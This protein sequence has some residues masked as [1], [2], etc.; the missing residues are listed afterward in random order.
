MI[1]RFVLQIIL[2]LIYISLA[3]H[4]PNPRAYSSTPRH[5]WPDLV[6]TH[7]NTNMLDNKAVP[8]GYGHTIWFE[9][10]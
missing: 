2:L 9:P 1:N 4:P 5:P 7:Q 3:L 10:V 6:Y 8:L